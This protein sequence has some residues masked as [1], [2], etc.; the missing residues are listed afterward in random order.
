MR[1]DQLSRWCARLAVVSAFSTVAVAFAAGAASAENQPGVQ[2]AGG[3]RT[4]S[5]A[6][7][8]TDSGVAPQ[9]IDWGAAPQDS[10]VWPQDIDWGVAPL[11]IDWGVA[12]LDI[13]WG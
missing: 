7:A 12:P 9:D 4:T 13:D 3:A 6:T 5:S 11:D 2:E 1:A 8:E 10:G